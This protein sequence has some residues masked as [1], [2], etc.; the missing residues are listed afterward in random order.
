M[1]KL[2]LFIAFFTT[3]NQFAQKSSFVLHSSRMQEDRE[4]TVVV[5]PSYEKSLQKKYPLLVL[6]DGEYLLDPFQ[7]A[8]SF[9][10]YWNDIPEMIIVA[11]KQNKKGERYTDTQVNE[12]TGLP[13]NK[14]GDFFEFIGQE[15]LPEIEKEF[16]ISPLRVI[17]GHDVTAA[18]I[19]FF[20]YKDKPIFNG[21]ISLSPE[22]S[23][24][25]EKQIPE[26]LKTIEQPIFYYLSTADGD[27]KT[28]QKRILDLNNAIKSNTKTSLNYKF[29]NFTNA[30]HYSL[31]LY[32]IPEAIYQ[33]F[34]IYQP[35]SQIEFTE[36]IA[37]LPSGYVDY[38]INKYDLIEK[39]LSIKIP[40]RYSDFKAIEA[41]II[42]NKAYD[43]MQQ[44]AVLALKTYPK[45]ML[46]DYEL[47]LMFE[48]TQN[49]EKAV[50]FY[51]KA[52]QKE[53]IGDLT[54]DMMYNK[55]EEL[56]NQ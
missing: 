51:K 4:I 18:Y 25:M 5:P 33:L 6:L 54:R 42:K 28:M 22:L 29:D 2:L 10:A 44:L 12:T 55:M 38:L 1:R 17:A 14:G 24:G 48:K 43:E 34:A 41:A 27:L 9:G 13:Q 19:N 11:I 47:A 16:R 49:Y 52:Y 45:S 40:I 53:E 39:T 21:Y 32:S 35:I 37:V 20:L 36:K 26:R 15:V 46:G 23:S 50:K 31:I 8:L 3:I 56:K 30:T 7:G